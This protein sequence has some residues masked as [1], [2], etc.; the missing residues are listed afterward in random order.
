[1]KLTPK[2]QEVLDRV[3]AGEHPNDIEEANEWSCSDGFSYG[4]YEGG[5]I[6]P[7][8]IL[9]GEDL[10]RVQKAIKDLGEFKALWEKIS[11]E[12]TMKETVRELIDLAVYTAIFAVPAWLWVW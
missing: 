2:A 6:D 7:A 10:E 4:L 3:N 9:V 12:M 1:M 5:H 11:I 8:T